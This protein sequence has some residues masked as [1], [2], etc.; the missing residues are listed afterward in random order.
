MLIKLDILRQKQFKLFC[1]NS[2]NII[3]WDTEL[4][5]WYIFISFIMLFYYQHVDIINQLFY[6]LLYTSIYFFSNQT[7]KLTYHSDPICSL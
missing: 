3:F 1:S 2:Y 6:I 5:P 7:L 4:F